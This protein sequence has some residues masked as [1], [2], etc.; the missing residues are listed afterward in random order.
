MKGI[1]RGKRAG[2]FTLVEIM[3]AIAIFSMIMIAIYSSWHM[4]ITGRDTGVRAAA[5]AQRNRMAMRTIEAALFG[6][7]MFQANAHHYAFEVDTSDPDFAF[8][9]F[10]SHLPRSFPGSGL[11]PGEP[12]RRVTFTV[13][14]GDFGSKNLVMY[15]MPMLEVPDRDHDPIPILLAKNVALFGVEFFDPRHQEWVVE[16]PNANEL[17]KQLQ[18]ALGIK[19]LDG[20]EAA[21]ADLRTVIIP[22]ATVPTEVQ[23][24]PPLE[25]GQPD[26]NAPPVLPPGESPPVENSIR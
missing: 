17:P 19:A 16:W 8:M 3:V 23:L 26:P 22:S 15:Q 4:I 21:S 10:V 6:A 13:E 1:L 24:T 12:L 18:V 7:Q 9:S 20:R 14:D 25:T 2:G 5:E 11:F